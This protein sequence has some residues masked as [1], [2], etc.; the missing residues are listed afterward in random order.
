MIIGNEVVD[1]APLFELND[2]RNYLLSTLILL[3]LCL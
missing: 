3:I 2:S 1:L